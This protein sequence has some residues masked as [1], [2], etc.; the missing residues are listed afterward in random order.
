[1]CRKGSIETESPACRRFYLE[2]KA[3]IVPERDCISQDWTFCRLSHSFFV[4]DRKSFS[5]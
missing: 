4:T 2:K 5:D 3:E 1:M